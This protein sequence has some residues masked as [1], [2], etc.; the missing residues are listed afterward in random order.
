[1]NQIDKTYES[2]F[3]YIVEEKG[4]SKR[5][6][7]KIWAK[8]ANK[9]SIT[10]LKGYIDKILTE[11]KQPSNEEKEFEQ[12]MIEIK[13]LLDRYRE[14]SSMTTNIP[15]NDLWT[16]Y[17]SVYAQHKAIYNP[18]HK[19]GIDPISYTSWFYQTKIRLME[20]SYDFQELIGLKAYMEV[21][22]YFIKVGSERDISNEDAI[23]S[24]DEL[25]DRVKRLKLARQSND[26]C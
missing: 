19:Q 25:W 23:G 10:N 1:M 3:S 12:G 14:L 7:N 17:A 26:V 20:L 6:A 5:Q 24:P 22:S 8:I 4:Y 11:E 9:P 2:V 15:L 16:K 21:L 13:P 18:S